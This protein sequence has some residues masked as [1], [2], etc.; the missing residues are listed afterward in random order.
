MKKNL[1]IL[2]ISMIFSCSSEDDSIDTNANCEVKVWSYSRN[3]NGEYTVSYGPTQNNTQ[4]VDVNK[5]TY[6]FYYELAQASNDMNDG[7]NVCW[8]GLHYKN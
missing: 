3:S 7:N 5:A 8:E 2:F 1:F 4:E 6:D